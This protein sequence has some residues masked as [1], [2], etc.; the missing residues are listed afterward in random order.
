MQ[1]IAETFLMRREGFAERRT[2]SNR[3]TARVNG[4][5]GIN[6]DNYSRVLFNLSLSCYCKKIVM[7]INTS[8][9]N[10]VCRE[11]DIDTSV[12]S[13]SFKVNMVSR[14]EAG[15]VNRMIIAQRIASV[16]GTKAPTMSSAAVQSAPQTSTRSP[17]EMAAVA[18]FFLENWMP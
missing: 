5:T 2:S 14:N 4:I 6:Y 13:C 1:L 7:P 12:R 18:K 8:I 17:T 9:V 16:S 3:K 10:I 11:S 15:N